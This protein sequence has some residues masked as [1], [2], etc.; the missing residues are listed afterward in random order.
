MIVE[1]LSLKESERKDL[2]CNRIHPVKRK[3]LILFFGPQFSKLYLSHENLITR[4]AN[5]T[6]KMGVFVLFKTDGLKHA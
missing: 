3:K 1:V 4:Y 2:K 5:Q 6:F